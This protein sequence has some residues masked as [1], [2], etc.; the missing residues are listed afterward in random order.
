MISKN[1]K[2]SLFDLENKNI[3]ITGSAGLLGSQYAQTLCE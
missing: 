1:I 3:V 2:N